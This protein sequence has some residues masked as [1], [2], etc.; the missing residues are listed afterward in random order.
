MLTWHA[1]ILTSFGVLSSSGKN[2]GANFLLE[3]LSSL[4]EFGRHSFLS[5]GVQIDHIVI[6]AIK[7][8]I[9]ILLRVLGLSPF[10]CR[11]SIHLFL[12]RV[13]VIAA[14][15]LLHSRPY[16]LLKVNCCCFQLITTKADP[17]G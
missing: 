7:V 1:L 15:P 6:G 9:W 5:C 11:L 16:S 2:C 13:S 14:L 12:G 4:Q 8:G 3:T 10:H 17:L